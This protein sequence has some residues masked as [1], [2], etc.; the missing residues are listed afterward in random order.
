MAV[1]LQS[2]PHKTAYQITNHWPAKW[3]LN[4]PVVT[5]A[6]L[7]ALLAAGKQALTCTLETLQITG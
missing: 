2:N 4:V 7:G 6:V 5:L 3:Y 1:D